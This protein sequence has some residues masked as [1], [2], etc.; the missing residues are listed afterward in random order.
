MMAKCVF[1]GFGRNENSVLRTGKKATSIKTFDT[2]YGNG[3]R[4]SHHFT[5]IKF[6]DYFK[7]VT[8]S[9]ETVS[10]LFKMT[11]KTIFVFFLVKALRKGCWRKVG[12]RV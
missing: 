12:V 4:V 2:R 1:L 5:Q 8:E 10:C 7:C 3:I 6:Y 11:L 9:R